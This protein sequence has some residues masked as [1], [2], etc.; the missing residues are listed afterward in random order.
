MRVVSRERLRD[1]YHVLWGP[2]A[3]HGSLES[4]LGLRTSSA[5]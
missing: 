3:L 4:F 2:D 5:P 1:V